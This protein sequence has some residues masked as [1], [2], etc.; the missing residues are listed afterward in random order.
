MAMIS[1]AFVYG[2][3]FGVLLAAV[4]G[5]LL[6]NRMARERDLYRKLFYEATG[7]IGRAR[8]GK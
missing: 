3:V 8:R 4:A 5:W 6:V 2:L 1:L 7:Q